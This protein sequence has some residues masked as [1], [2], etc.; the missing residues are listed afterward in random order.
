MSSLNNTVDVDE[1]ID[2]SPIA[3]L[4]ILVLLL[5]TM[6]IFVDGFNIQVIGYIAPQLAKA[7]HIPNELLGP[8]FSSGLFGVFGGYLFLAPISGHVGHRLMIIACTAILGILTLLTTLV[9]DAYVLMALRFITGL[10][11]GATN[12]SAVSIIAD[13]CPSR[14]RS[15]FVVTGICGVSL[16]SMAAGLSAAM[17]MGAYGWEVVLIIG[18][19]L[20]LVLA[21]ILTVALPDSLEYLVKKKG[22]SAP[23]TLAL[24][25]RIA[26]N[27]TLIAGTKFS[28]TQKASGAVTQIFVEERL[29]GTLAIW[30]CFTANLLV[31]YFVQS[32]LTTL[33]IAAGHTQQV[34]VSATT[35]LAAG[36]VL[37]IFAVG[38]LMDKYQPFKVIGLFFV[39][40]GACVALLGSLL[41][42]SA[43]IVLVASF[44]AGF[45]V[46]GVQKGMNAVAVY[47][48]P[49]PLR[50][51]G[52]GWGLG[53]GRLGAVAG[54]LVAGIL[55]Q[56]GQASATLFYFAA[57]PML[58][59]AT[60]MS[61]M[62]AR[63]GKRPKGFSQLGGRHDAV[64]VLP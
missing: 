59:G 16:G 35:V 18:G 61:F 12:P 48:Y 33:I 26:P 57:I 3:T 38:P 19:A 8:I 44:L 63:Y 50:S 64:R 25:R 62:V 60:A 31:F 17:L 36:G 2:D 6:V 54:P 39:G 22:G 15:T 51:T 46:L 37:S 14:R 32:W 21:A 9:H 41:T 29:F 23:E 10:S 27:R 34:A 53:V 30:I 49:T 4:Q 56:G 1:L 5:G 45:T 40:G 24:A 7:W 28:F 13:F 42:A 11:L 58:A 55:M 43:P 47:F 20:P 52:L